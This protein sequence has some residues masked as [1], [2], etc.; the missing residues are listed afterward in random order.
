MGW[1]QMHVHKTT[2]K[3]TGQKDSDLCF[4][5][6]TVSSKMLKAIAQAEGMCFEV[7]KW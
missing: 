6:S 3:K 2:L 7:R 1:W 5:A 4:L